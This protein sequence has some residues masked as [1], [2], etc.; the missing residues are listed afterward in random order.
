MKE[1]RIPFDI[2]YKPQIESGEYK[3]E[4]EDGFPATI[5]DWSFRKD[6]GSPY[7]CVKITKN[8]EDYAFLYSEDGK[9]FAHER[10]KDNDLIIITPEL[11]ESEDKKMINEL[12]GFLSSFGAHY[13]GS[14][15]W[16]KFDDWLERQKEQK[17]AEWKPQPE[18]LEA[19]MYAIEGKWEMIKPTSYLSRRL[20]DL[21][22]GLV[23]AFNVDETLL[24]EL[25]KTAYTAKDIEELKKLKDKIEASMD[26]KSVAHENDSESK[27]AEG[28]EK[29]EDTYKRVYSLF[30]QAI[31]SWYDFVFA[32][33]YPKITREKVLSM[34]KSLHHQP[35]QEWGEEDEK[36]AYFVNQFLGYHENADPTAKSCK[37]WF[38][39]RLK[40][41]RPQ[42]NWKPS[43]VQMSMKQQ[44]RD[45]I[46]RRRDFF[47]ERYVKKGIGCIEESRYDECV[48]ILSFIDS[49]P[50]CTVKTDGQG[51]VKDDVYDSL[52][53]EPK[54]SDKW[55][56][57]EEQMNALEI[58]I[59][60][61]QSTA[62]ESLYNDLKKL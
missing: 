52:T 42:S 4:T 12:Q 46:E 2:K 28:S 44:I 55:K 3:V 54:S 36:M 13:F 32:G 51:R 24:T 49:L 37:K 29:D 45:E 11:A 48:E 21:Y 40:S 56:P 6:S 10:L 17:S 59:S 22:E 33:C 18:S 15:E 60:N 27:P 9:R 57:S 43:E 47:Y 8:G 58:A 7:I 61:L 23:N 41:L 25:S 39:N 31:D 38:N 62:L 5:L 14:G 53:D 50:D 1:N 19:L 35:K 30:D 20:E 26:K 16:H 34:L